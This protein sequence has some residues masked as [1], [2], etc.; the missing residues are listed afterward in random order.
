M[1]LYK[2]LGLKNDSNQKRGIRVLPRATN[3]FTPNKTVTEVI[4]ETK[5]QHDIGD[6]GRIPVPTVFVSLSRLFPIGETRLS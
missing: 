6:S 4:K 3:H 2:R 5:K 1:I